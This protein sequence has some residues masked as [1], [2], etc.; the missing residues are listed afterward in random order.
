MKKKFIICMLLVGLVG[1]CISGC[2]SGTEHFPE[3]VTEDYLS[4]SR[5]D[6]EIRML[7]KKVNEL[8]L[9]Y[10]QEHIYMDSVET[11]NGAVIAAAFL[12]D[13]LFRGAGTAAQTVG[14]IAVHALDNYNLASPEELSDQIAQWK[15]GL[16]KDLVYEIDDYEVITPSEANTEEQALVRIHQNIKV[17]FV[18]Y[19][20]EV[21]LEFIRQDDIWKFHIVSQNS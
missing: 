9:D 7:E 12:G 18:S 3:T 10:L 15:D 5:V 17:G 11:D 13:M 19:S 14:N 20:G 1:C 16:L 2:N 6:Q 8:D 21:Y 4:G